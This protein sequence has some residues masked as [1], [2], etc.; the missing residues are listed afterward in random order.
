M[1]KRNGGSAEQIGVRRTDSATCRAKRYTVEKDIP[2]HLL[3]PT[4]FLIK[5]QCYHMK[6]KSHFFRLFF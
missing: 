6:Q 5:R 3:F 2:V 4:N 1:Q